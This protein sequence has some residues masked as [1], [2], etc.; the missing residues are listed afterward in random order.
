MPRIRTAP[1]ALGLGL[2][3]GLGVMLLGWI[4]ASGWGARVVDLL[5]SVYLGYAATFLGGL[6]GGLWAFA[7]AFVAGALFAFFYNAL[8]GR[9]AAERHLSVRPE[10]VAR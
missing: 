6:I 5:S 1:L 4:A 7:D 10:P 9:Q 2:T 8:S 3:W